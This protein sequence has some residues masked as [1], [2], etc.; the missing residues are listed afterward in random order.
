MSPHPDE[1][2]FIKI[3]GRDTRGLGR[4]LVRE[5]LVVQKEPEFGSPKRG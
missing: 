4:W 1:T 2:G 3:Q 5:M